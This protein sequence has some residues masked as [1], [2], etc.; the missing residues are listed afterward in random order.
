MH[1]II[2]IISKED[3]KQ[4][5]PNEDLTATTKSEHSHVRILKEPDKDLFSIHHHFQQVLKHPVTAED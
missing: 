4:Q 3:A 1:T 2:T 5:I